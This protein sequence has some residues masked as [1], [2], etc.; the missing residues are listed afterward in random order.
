VAP[1]LGNALVRERIPNQPP[2]RP[3]RIG[4][5]KRRKPSFNRTLSKIRKQGQA[6]RERNIEEKGGTRE[7]AGGEFKGGMQDMIK[8][9]QA[10]SVGRGRK[11]RQSNTPPRRAE[12]QYWRETLWLSWTAHTSKD[13]LRPKKKKRGKKRGHVI[14]NPPGPCELPRKYTLV[15]S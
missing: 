4:T 3:G 15:F 6:L 13:G 9:S 7:E 10:E 12:E 14:A 2:Q 1:N 5:K 11:E 8:D